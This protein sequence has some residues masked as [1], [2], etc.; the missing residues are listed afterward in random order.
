MSKPNQILHVAFYMGLRD[1]KSKQS[2]TP[3]VIFYPGYQFI[4]FATIEKQVAVQSSR[5]LLDQVI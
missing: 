1:P 3:L 4:G 5:D 2:R